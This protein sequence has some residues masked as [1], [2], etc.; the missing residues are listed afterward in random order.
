MAVVPQQLEI[1]ICSCLQQ[2][3]YGEFAMSHTV[4]APILVTGA[5]GQIGSV[6]AMIVEQLLK[7]GEQVRAFV[8]TDDARADR[9][10]G[11]GAETF[12][13]DLFDPADVAAALK[14][15]RR[16]YF[17]MGLSP[18]YAD[19]V[20]V[21]AV[22]AR[23]VPDFELLVAISEYEQSFMGWDVL[24]GP[25][26]ERR[27]AF[28]GTVE[29]WSPQQRAHWTSE[30]ILDWSGV[31]V[32]HVRATIF[33]ENPL[34]TWFTVDGLRNGEL[35][36][37]FGVARFS[38]I[39]AHDVA[40]ACVTILR[41]P[42]AHAGRTYLLTGPELKTMNDLARDF[43]QVLGRDIVYVPQP[44]KP[45]IDRR[46]IPALGERNPHVAEHLSILVR[47]IEGGTHDAVTDAL[48]NLLDR[49]PTTAAAALAATPILRD[50]GKR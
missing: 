12:V 8:R 36:L 44:V 5:G 11:L 1:S 18:S 20:A 25:V 47:M 10:R 30:K 42:V 3:V 17:S 15:C 6:S 34:L 28:G 14:G 41:A 33:Y 7:Q 26:E 39:A 24:S 38:P 23:E 46:I 27:A 50:L 49:A 37:P 4:S 45:W 40:D 32:T 29:T 48:A 21:M 13:G 31:P 9:L 22:A 2:E 43:G 19:A 16:A 35:Q